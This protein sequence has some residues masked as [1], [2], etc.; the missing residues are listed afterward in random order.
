MPE[1]LP[2]GVVNPLSHW[3]LRPLLVPFHIGAWWLISDL[4]LALSGTHE[5]FLSWLN[6]LDAPFLWKLRSDQAGDYGM[7][8]VITY[9]IFSTRL[10][11]FHVD[12]TRL[13]AH[14]AHLLVF[15]SL[16]NC[17]DRIV[18]IVSDRPL[19]EACR[20]DH[21]IHL[22]LLS[23]IRASLLGQ[24]RLK[25][26]FIP[27]QE[28]LRDILHHFIPPRRLWSGFFMEIIFF[29]DLVGRVQLTPIA[30]SYL[31]HFV[32]LEVHGPLFSVESLLLSL[33]DLLVAVLFC[34]RDPVGL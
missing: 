21:I 7:S 1:D 13:T 25:R 23:F 33:G 15:P 19:G 9:Y 32:L 29:S 26:V 12:P 17:V 31:A 22:S 4:R 8:L 10:P 27:V 20:A 5:P 3:A 28:A 6:F 2:H 14:Q 16:G 11:S 34:P 30:G 24:M 18:F